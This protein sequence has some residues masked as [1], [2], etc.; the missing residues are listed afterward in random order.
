MENSRTTKSVL[1]TL[2]VATLLIAGFSAGAAYGFRRGYA[3]A[4]KI[5]TAKQV[6]YSKKEVAELPHTVAYFRFLTDSRENMFVK[7]TGNP[8]RDFIALAD[9]QQKNIRELC[10]IYKPFSKNQV[11]LKLCD[12]LL[13]PA[14]DR[15]G[16]NAEVF[17][18]KTGLR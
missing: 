12:D 2:G 3:A 16:T 13:L 11:A 1:I 14:A 7:F 17:F 15:F 8:D 10:E 9:A 5:L 18:N 4:D 6:H